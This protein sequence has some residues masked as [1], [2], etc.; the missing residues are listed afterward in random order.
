MQATLHTNKGDITIEF[1]TVNTPKT[2]EN[3]I[4]LAKEGFYNG[5]K[6]HE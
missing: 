5:V 4:K 6:F 2:A 1:D 3:F